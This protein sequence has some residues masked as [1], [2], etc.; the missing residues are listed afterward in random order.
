M[1][2]SGKIIVIV[3][4]LISG[5][6]ISPLN[7]GET[8][9]SPETPFATFMNTDWIVNAPE[10]HS[11]EVIVLTGNLT[12][13]GTG[14]L[15]FSNVTLIMNVTGTDGDYGITV[16]D[17]GRFFVNDTD[18]N[19]LTTG[20]RSKISNNATFDRG[21]TFQVNSSSV[22]EM[23]NSRLEGC[24]L[25][26]TMPGRNESGPLILSDDVKIIGSEIT[27]CS[28]GLYIDSANPFIINTTIHSNTQN[29]LYFTNVTDSAHPFNITLENTTIYNNLKAGIYLIGDTAEIVL[30]DNYIHHN[31]QG[32]VRMNVGH[33]AN[34]TVTNNTVQYNTGKGGIGMWGLP[35]V[36][37]IR[38]DVRGNNISRNSGFSSLLVGVQYSEM[39]ANAVFLN[40]TEN[41]IWIS[42]SGGDPNGDGMILAYATDYIYAN[43]SDNMMFAPMLQNG[44]NVGKVTPEI[45][46]NAAC[47][48]VDA[49]ILGNEIVNIQGGALKIISTEV[50]NANVTDNHVYHPEGSMGCGSVSV[51]WYADK[52]KDSTPKNATVVV[53]NNRFEGI[54]DSGGMAIKAIY[55]L[56]ATIENNVLGK[57]NNVGV[58][59]WGFKL[60]WVSDD[61]SRLSP[62][63][64]WLPTRNVRAVIR[65]NTIGTGYGPGIWVF[66]SNGTEVYDNK[67]TGRSD[68]IR[69][70]DTSNGIKIYNNTV[71]SGSAT[72]IEVYNC[73]GVSVFNNIL[74]SNQYG[75]GVNEHSKNNL[76]FDNVITKYN[77]QYGYWVST[78]SF[79]HVFP[80]NNT[81]NGQWFRYYH[82]FQGTPASHLAL[83]GHVVTEPLMSNLGQIVLV[84]ATYA[85]ITGNTA[86]NGINGITLFKSNNTLIR[87]NTLQNNENF[88]LNGGT[89]VIL[90][91]GSHNNTLEGNDFLDN[92]NSIDFEDTSVD[93]TIW[94]NTIL[95]QAHQTAIYFDTDGSSWRNTVAA[96]NSAGGSP[97]HYYYGIE[98]VT[99]SNLSIQEPR[100]TNYG[101][102]VVLNS[103]NTT[104]SNITVLNGTTGLY[105]RDS[106]NVAVENSNLSLNA[107][108]LYCISSTNLTIESSVLENGTA[109]VR[110]TSSSPAILNSTIG[111]AVNEAFNLTDGS[112]HPVLRNTTFNSSQ[113]KIFNGSDITVEWY[114]EV[115]VFAN[116]LPCEG[117][118]M[119]IT[120]STGGV[121][122]NLTTGA[123]GAFRLLPLVNY[124]NTSS[125]IT[126]LSAYTLT[127]EKENFSDF[128]VDFT[129]NRSQA[130]NINITDIVAPVLTAP[131][132]VPSSIG[133]SSDYIWLNASISDSGFGDSQI[134]EAEWYISDS[135]PS[136]AS[137]TGFPILA[138]DGTYDE[139]SEGLSVQ[140]DVDNWQVSSHTLWIH[141]RDV[142]N[143]WCPWS[144]A[145]LTIYDDEGPKATAGP[146]MATST[147]GISEDEISIVTVFD[148]TGFGNSRIFGVEWTVTQGNDLVLNSLSPLASTRVA[149]GNYDEVNE[150]VEA[151][152]DI[153]F[154]DIGDYSFEIRGYDEYG[155]FGPWYIVTFELFDNTPPSTPSNIVATDSESGAV[156]TWAP[157]TELDVAG[158][159]IYRSSISGSGYVLVGTVGAGT[160]TWTDTSATAGSTYYY[161][162]TAF[163]TSIPPNESPFS[164][165]TAITY[166]GQSDSP[167]NSY[168]WML[169]PVLVLFVVILA[170][171]LLLR[172]KKNGP[173]PDEP[174]KE[175]EPE[176]EPKDR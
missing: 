121:K 171:M 104:L 157:N 79:S 1:A 119:N 126:N 58:V 47:K 50:L 145:V 163:D 69:I 80:A 70:D 45:N 101:Q 16:Q 164:S 53:R 127:V 100:M 138:L 22:F 18:G 158:Y 49:I 33:S 30:N 142:W 114:L 4:L 106:D 13:T 93:N 88:L 131:S 85:D 148:D 113:V 24:G 27:G 109:S 76:F 38:A 96:N 98:G 64:E 115:S 2:S 86:S 40:A 172:S 36:C 95:K 8:W 10:S 108:N 77:Y 147:V 66:S 12:V 89:G 35:G 173:K 133:T 120:N 160:L 31:G 174:P 14:T 71:S 170:A 168:W 117:A 62:A 143:N 94:N 152:I 59:E 65:N 150:T 82:N 169:I 37:V 56:N 116:G 91:M 125:N 28:N 122:Y 7:A 60:G 5:A 3:I 51:G 21:F 165:E 134:A 25:F 20:D 154:W 83:T 176:L 136:I 46:M 74:N 141:G 78:D 68:G 103:R 112:C 105:I 156:L 9:E 32:G 118:N 132:L 34:A 161:V 57:A 87:G 110:L 159:N 63:P 99:V 43:I 61:D 144:S 167:A 39:P 52:A 41:D 124:I 137:G 146:N 153:M 111:Q 149:D 166:L 102:F 42:D 23:R 17:G 107:Y 44:L 90:T 130:F 123:E 11:D 15:D 84:N 135:V 92:F 81:V 155:N 128:T 67:I 97:V 54:T 29:G 162:I 75:L 19:P 26:G 139:T 6:V 140:I 129:M 72:G 175:S 73:T 48:A 55:N 151:E